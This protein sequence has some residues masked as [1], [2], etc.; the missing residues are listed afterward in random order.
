MYEYM[1]VEVLA[2]GF[3]FKAT[4]HRDIIDSHAKEG[5]RFVGTVITRVTEHGR[6]KELDLIFERRIEELRSLPNGSFTGYC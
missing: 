4:D 3:I 1:Y 2:A 6:P 5:W